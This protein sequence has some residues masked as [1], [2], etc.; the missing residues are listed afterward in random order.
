MDAVQL[1]TNPI[2]AV[3]NRLGVP[4]KYLGLFLRNLYEGKSP[5]DGFDLGDLPL[6]GPVWQRFGGNALFDSTVKTAV[7]KVEDSGNI[8]NMLPSMFSTAY[9]NPTRAEDVKTPEQMEKF[10]YKQK[11][12]YQKYDVEN[13]TSQVYLNIRRNKTYP[14]KMSFKR[15]PVWKAINN[16]KQPTR[17]YQNYYTTQRNIDRFARNNVYKRLYTTTGYSRMALNMGPT[18]AKNLKYR[19][20]AIRNMYRYK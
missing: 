19:I 20:A 13:G 7:D 11:M 3:S 6:V 16:Y 9:L 8:L 12:L 15:T 17:R 1:A 14:R 5:I 18:T 4:Y 10:L 2:D